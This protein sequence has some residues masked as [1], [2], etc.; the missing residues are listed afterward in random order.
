MTTT[1]SGVLLLS[2]VARQVLARDRSPH[3]VNVY[4]IMAQPVLSVSPEMDIRYCARLFERFDLSRA[5]VIDAD[6]EV[7][8]IVSSTDMVL[9]GLFAPE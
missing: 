9:H 4:E 5:A 6:G 8:G 2:D 3:R 1:R 7:V